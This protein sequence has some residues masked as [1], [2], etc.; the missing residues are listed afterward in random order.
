MN[1]KCN[2]TFFKSIAFSCAHINILFLNKI[3][4]IVEKIYFSNTE[5]YIFQY[6]TQNIYFDK[7]NSQ[8]VSVQMYKTVQHKK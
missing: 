8:S 1:Q 4:V 2:S 7:L 3:V 6:I 5:K